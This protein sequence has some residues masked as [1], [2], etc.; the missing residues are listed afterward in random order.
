METK[1]K[2]GMQGIVRIQLKDK[3]G[4]RK[5]LFQGNRLWDI[6]HGLVGIDLKVPYITGK[7]TLEMVSGNAIKDAGLAVAAK[8][9]GG[10]TA[11]PISYIAIGKGTG[12]TTTLN[13]EITTGGGAR[14]SATISSQ[15]KNVS[16]DTVRC[17]HTFAFT[18]SF[19]VTEE[20]LFNA[21]SEG[22]LIAYKEFSA[23]GVADGDSLEITH[24]VTMSA[25]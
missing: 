12:G 24:D 5:P 10:I 21:S 14:A 16:G 11:N 25:S 15:T 6:I 18:A 1:E 9:L 19:S 17:T 3:R 4:N 23:I 7:W 2:E 20:G 22:D 13:D 8:R